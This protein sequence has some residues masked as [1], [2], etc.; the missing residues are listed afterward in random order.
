MAAFLL[1]FL[2]ENACAQGQGQ[3]ELQR[4]NG[5]ITLDGLSDEPAWEAI[6]PLPMTMYL[7]VFEGQTT[8]RTEIRVA[9]N[10]EYIYVSGRLYD[11]DPSGI[12]INSLYRDRYNGDDAFAIYLDTFNDN[13][14]ALWFFTTPSGIRGDLAVSGDDE[15]PAN[16]SW[17]TF[18][19][20]ATTVTAEGWFAE[21]R[22]PLS[23][24]R[25]RELDGKVVMGLT[26]TRFISR[27]NERVTFPA[28]P[29]K[30]SFRK[31]S[32]AQDVV[33]RGIHSSKPFYVT[34]YALA[35]V[36]RTAL[37]DGQSVGYSYIRDPR[38]ELGIDAK[39]S[40]T[41]NLTLD[42]TINTDFAQVEVDD[43]QINLTRYSLFYPEKRQFFQERASLFSFDQGDGNLL[44]HS[45][46]I[47]LTDNGEPVR[48][49]GGGRLVGKVGDWD[50]GVIDMHTAPDGAS[51]LSENFGV[52]RL[53]R[54]V[55]NEYSYLGGMMTSRVD[56]NGTYNFGYGLDGVV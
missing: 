50:M 43:Q 44:F 2:A 29:P 25:F 10:D 39:Y 6:T 24:L 22:I 11:S 46:R 7:P 47:G 32:V 13:E 35:G 8:E 53:R 5:N 54:P 9:Y 4:I 45:R 20:V 34:P 56:K 1:L 23:S 37:R 18:W 52:L 33:L 3:M 41:D 49:L 55:F 38:N 17:N 26:V 31:P 14:N 48:I 21:I 16:E 36:S 40:L 27:K 19:D 28:I 42:A 51:A 12:R 30:F 15:V